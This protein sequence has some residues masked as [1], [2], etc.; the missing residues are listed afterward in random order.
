[1]SMRR[2]DPDEWARQ[3]SGS[4]RAPQSGPCNLS[5][6]D[7]ARVHTIQIVLAVCSSP[8]LLPASSG[9]SLIGRHRQSRQGGRGT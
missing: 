1:M 4:L 5:G 2:H 7:V 9:G 6:E 3:I 8:C